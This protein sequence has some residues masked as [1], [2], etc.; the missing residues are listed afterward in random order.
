MRKLLAICLLVLLAFNLGG[1]R[2]LYDYYSRNADK[3]LVHAI[4]WQHYSEEELIT[5]R[6][7]THLPYY[8][9][10]GDFRS[11]RGEVEIDGIRYQYVQYRIINDSI[12]LRC[13]PNRDK[14]QLLQ[15]VT[16]YAGA[17]GGLQQ[18]LPGKQPAQGIKKITTGFSE[19]E[20][21]RLYE[22]MVHFTL[23]SNDFVLVDS[24]P[25][26]NGFVTTMEQPPDG[27]S[28]S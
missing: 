24:V 19:Y 3:A 12:E 15:A 20:A 6:Q 1:Y 16:D 13:I 22:L 18:D 14:M 27:R 2:L 4:D 10:H 28:F 23:L 7:P 5:F 8:G 21:L 11:V 9:N 17:A 26:E 25:E